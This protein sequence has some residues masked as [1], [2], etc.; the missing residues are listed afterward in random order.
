M[1]T[2]SGRPR[3]TRL[4]AP[5]ALLA[6]ALL[7]QPAAAVT[8]LTVEGETIVIHV[9]IDMRGLRRATIT[10]PATG[11]RFEAASYIEREVERIWNEAFEGFSYACWKFRLD[12]EL[13][14]IGFESESVPGHHLVVMDMKRDRSHWDAT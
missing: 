14:P 12:L 9:P 13:F 4:G 8:S 1:R 6:S 5:A 3:W 2:F 7:C 11:E 10:N